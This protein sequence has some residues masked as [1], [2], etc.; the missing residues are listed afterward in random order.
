LL[1]YNFLLIIIIYAQEILQT[2][3][4]MPRY[5]TTEFGGSQVKH[6][7]V[8]V[9]F[10]MFSLQSRFLTS[11]VNPSQTHNNMYGGWGQVN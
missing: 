8:I 10:N 6:Q 9:V 2:R 11:L 5:I 4:P 1:L 7:E 3:F